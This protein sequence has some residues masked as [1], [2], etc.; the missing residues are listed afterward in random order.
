MKKTNF[1]FVLFLSLVFLGYANAEEFTKEDKE[2]LRNVELKVERLEVKVEAIQKQIDD[3]KVEIKDI[4][5]EI[6]TLRSDLQG[7]ML[8]GFGILFGSMLALVGF[9]IWDRRTALEPAIKRN[10][11]LEKVLMEIAKKDENVK[12][13]LE[14][15]GLL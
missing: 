13:A 8:W 10:E 12:E 1:I 7:F 2:R 15:A 11:K 9:V 14:N 4:R 6:Q 5:A 3:L